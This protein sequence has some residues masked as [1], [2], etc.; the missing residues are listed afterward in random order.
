M[1]ESGD[2]GVFVYI[3]VSGRAVASGDVMAD[4]A[5]IARMDYSGLTWTAPGDSRTREDQL[6]DNGNGPQHRKAEHQ[7][8]PSRRAERGRSSVIP[9][10]VSRA[11]SKHLR[12]DLRSPYYSCHRIT[13]ELAD[14]GAGRPENGGVFLWCY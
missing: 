3:F 12:P 13:A 8:D 7:Q 1:L 6:R 5:G 11:R 9:A 10:P 2:R 4:A 14:A